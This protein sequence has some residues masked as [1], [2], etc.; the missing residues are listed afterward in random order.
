MPNSGG[1]PVVFIVDEDAAVRE[2]LTRLMDSAG[3]EARPCASLTEFL[4]Q[5]RS[6]RLACVLLD[7][8][9]VRACGADERAALHTVATVLPVIA[10]SSSDDPAVRQLARAVGAEAFFRK[11]VDGAALLD[12][13]EWVMQGDGHP[14]PGM[15]PRAQPPR[16]A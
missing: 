8:M 14:I 4:Q 10:L 7:V 16:K 1:P 15:E 13:I 6:M 2:A 12:T 5:A 9:S 3:L 11:P